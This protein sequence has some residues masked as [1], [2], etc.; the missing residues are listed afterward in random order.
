MK[1]GSFGSTPD[2][3]LNKIQALSMDYLKP[4]LGV[5][6]D[7]PL[8]IGEVVRRTDQSS[9]IQKTVENYEQEVG[10]LQM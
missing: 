7:E 4:V 6:R 3:R 8:N 1:Y 9:A 2:Y 5:R 10:Q